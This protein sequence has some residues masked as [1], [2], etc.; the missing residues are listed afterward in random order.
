MKP[1]PHVVGPLGQLQVGPWKESVPGKLGVVGT[2]R[3][4]AALPMSIIP[5]LATGAT[6]REEGAVTAMARACLFTWHGLARSYAR[7][8]PLTCHLAPAS[9]CAWD[10]GMTS[11]V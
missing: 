5:A 4:L 2:G 11:L 9:R 3:G 8:C 6:R 1:H 10:L 7:D